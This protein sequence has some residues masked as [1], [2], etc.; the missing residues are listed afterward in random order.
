MGFALRAFGLVLVLV[1]CLVPVAGAQVDAGGDEPLV[2]GVAPRLS[3][4]AS[5]ARSTTARWPEL[6]GAVAAVAQRAER[7][8]RAG[9]HSLAR[10]SGLVVRPQGVRVVVSGG[11]SRAALAAVGGVVEAQSGELT[12]G[13]VPADRLDSLATDSRVSGVRA[14]HRFRPM[15][16]AGEGVA[17]SNASAYLAAGHSGQGEKIA[18]IDLGFAGYQQRIADGELPAVTTK[19]LCGGQLSTATPHGTGVA[20]I[21][22][23]TAPSARLY[24]ICVNSEVTLAQAL[25]FAKQQQVTIVNHSVGWFNT[26]RGDGS[27]GPGTPDAIVADARANGILWVN[28]AGN[29]AGRHWSG[30][31]TDVDT[32]GVHEFAGSDVGNSFVAANG[33]VVCASLKWDAWPTTFKDF[34]L[35]IIRST[36]NEVLAWSETDQSSVRDTPTEETCWENATGADVAVAAAVTKVS[37]PDHPRMDLFVDGALQYPTVQ[38]S[39]VEPASSPAAL[40]VGA[41]CWKYD[42]S[43]VVESFSSQ[44]PTIDGRIKPDLV[45]P[46]GV[47]S[48]TYGAS[49]ECQASGFVGTSAAAPHVAGALALL[50]ENEPS[51]SL[52]T[53]E[54]TLLQNARSRHGLDLNDTGAGMLWLPFPAPAGGQIVYAQEPG[55]GSGYR[56]WQM[57]DNGDGPIPLTTSAAGEMQNAVLSPDGSKLAYVSNLTTQLHIYVANADGS[58]ATQ[59]SFPGSAYEQSPHWSPDGSKLAFTA[60]IGN[61]DQVVVTDAD[62]GNPLQLTSGNVVSHTPVWSPDGSTIAFISDRDDFPRTDVYQMNADGTAVTRLTTTA[63]IDEMGPLWSPNGSKIALSADGDAYVMNAN[64]SGAVLVTSA[65]S[66]SWASSWSPDGA[67]LLLSS[68]FGLYLAATDGSTL[69]R[70]PLA[71]RQRGATWHAGEPAPSN[72]T[73]PSISGEVVEGH[74]LY[75]SR[76]RWL[77]AANRITY[78][79]QRCD[80]GLASC[81]NIAGATDRIYKLLAADLGSRLRVVATATN[82]T[83]TGSAQSAG[84]A[85]VAAAPPAEVGGGSG[86]G[87]GGDGGGGGGGGGGTSGSA[88]LG[89]EGYAQ[90]A[91]AAVGEDVTYYLKVTDV[92][93][94]IALGVNVDVELPAGAQLVNSYSDRGPG[95]SGST[96]LVC[97]LD[98]MTSDGPTSNITVR[99]KVA[100]P[101]ELALKASVRYSAADPKPE[102]NSVT[103][104]ANR[105]AAPVPLPPTR[106]GPAT[107]PVPTTK[108]GNAR[109]NTLRGGSRA[110]TLRGLGGN[111]TLYGLGGNDRLFGGSGNDRLFGGLGRDLLDGGPGND[112]ISARDRARDTIRCGRGRDTVTADRIDTIARDCER[113]TRR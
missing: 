78:Q 87:G 26:S 75:V 48:A 101:G 23:E 57:A 58:G 112:T 27:G 62:G 46:D 18:I 19:D 45:G 9:A 34:D 33:S 66:E 96:S 95:C 63:G 85:A 93:L 92:N 102:N 83:A 97:S 50:K 70:F 4:D 39:I 13:L 65:L 31:F 88:D 76:G 7:S 37:S 107:T 69:R 91:T 73:G 81:S 89:I 79:W 32:D 24:L 94:G 5:P 108:T 42:H 3:E 49:D 51:A 28:A 47:S 111:D 72:I 36:D 43:V 6:Q 103:I 113:V 104:V 54:T 55:P 60:H 15:A 109:A 80:A 61:Y 41:R 52:P 40:A 2:T 64:G 8:G 68:G 77:G 29:E 98:W 22:H 16:V 106:P 35:Y 56:I 100:A 67:S 12:Q 90:P 84:S 105:A 21:V 44:G 25:L 1:V 38:G 14:P 17:E 30:S 82:L 99:V 20:E 74:I 59:I 110:D 53:L 71:G 10:S 86:G 11:G